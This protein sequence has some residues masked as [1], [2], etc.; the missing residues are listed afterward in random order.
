VREK[1]II[2]QN[3]R[4][5]VKSIDAVEASSRPNEALSGVRCAPLSQVVSQAGEMK[6]HFVLLESLLED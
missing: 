6:M 3:R 5:L 1:R 2:D 4:N